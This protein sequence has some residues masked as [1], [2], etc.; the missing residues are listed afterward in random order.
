MMKGRIKGWQY[1]KYPVKQG[2]QEDFSD[3]EYGTRYRD[4][5]PAQNDGRVGCNEK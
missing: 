3:T 1:M 2:V 5:H 4:K